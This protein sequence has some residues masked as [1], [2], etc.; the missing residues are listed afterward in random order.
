MT[1]PWRLRQSTCSREGEWAR[2]VGW[3]APNSFGSL[4]GPLFRHALADAR[5]PPV[6]RSMCT[7]QP[8]CSVLDPAST[9]PPASSTGLAR[10]GPRIPAG[11]RIG[12]DHDRPWSVDV[13]ARPHH[14]RGLGPTL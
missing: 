1:T 2:I 14:S 12:R 4:S 5:S 7:T 11:S 6:Q 9:S 13:R 8:A 3:I 10:I